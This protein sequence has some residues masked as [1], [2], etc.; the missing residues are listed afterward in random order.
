MSVLGSSSKTVDFGA[1]VNVCEFGE[2]AAGSV[3]SGGKQQ[4]D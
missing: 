3:V 1:I 2:D 4:L